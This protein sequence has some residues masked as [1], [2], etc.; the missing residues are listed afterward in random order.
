M[1]IIIIIIMTVHIL[2]RLDIYYA[3]TG[4][5]GSVTFVNVPLRDMNESLYTLRV[6]GRTADGVRTVIRR[7]VRIGESTKFQLY[8]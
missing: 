1:T 4:S 2:S 7:R 6:I 3:C 8:C 5:S